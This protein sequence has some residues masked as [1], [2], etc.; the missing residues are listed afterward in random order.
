M[1]Q[2]CFDPTIFIK[3]KIQKWSVKEMKE[4]TQR[5]I[6]SIEDREMR[7]LA[8]YEMLIA[9]GRSGALR[10]AA[11]AFYAHV[12]EAKRLKAVA[13]RRAAQIEVIQSTVAQWDAR[14]VRNAI[15]VENAAKRQASAVERQAIQEA[16]NE[17]LALEEIVPE[18]DIDDILQQVSAALGIELPSASAR[19]DICQRG[20]KSMED[21]KRNLGPSLATFISNPVESTQNSVDEHKVAEELIAD[22]RRTALMQGMMTDEATSQKFEAAGATRQAAEDKLTEFVKQLIDR[23][24]SPLGHEVQAPSYQTKTNYKN[25]GSWFRPYGTDEWLPI[26]P[27]SRLCDADEVRYDFEADPNDAEVLESA[28][29]IV[30]D[31][32]D[33]GMT[34]EQLKAMVRRGV[35]PDRP[36]GIMT[37]EEALMRM[38][39]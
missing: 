13:E 2:D 14:A 4:I 37:R 6:R 38:A 26:T 3:T 17:V 31:P 16:V 25:V 33:A 29:A 19:Q 11:D 9:W 12:A 35:P 5:D 1:R 23:V 39:T 10:K 8:R 21:L 28:K 15:A 20:P 34:I 27:E 30:C 36:P 7:E 18:K 22:V 32:F 24:N